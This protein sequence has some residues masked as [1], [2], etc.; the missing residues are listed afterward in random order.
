MDGVGRV[1]S[2][3]DNRVVRS[4]VARGVKE[5]GMDGPMESVWRAQQQKAAARFSQGSRELLESAAGRTTGAGVSPGL[6]DPLQVL[7][8]SAADYAASP[9]PA[10]VPETHAGIWWKGT[11]QQVGLREARERGVGSSG[12]SWQ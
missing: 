4:G 1:E 7:T 2:D 3:D 5:N 8:R 9:V 10:A 12:W 11:G 6:P